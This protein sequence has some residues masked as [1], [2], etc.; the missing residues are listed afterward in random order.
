MSVLKKIRRLQ[1]HIPEAL[2]KDQQIITKQLSSII[3]QS[4]TQDLKTNLTRKLQ[5]LEH[6]LETSIKQR[7]LRLTSKPD[8]TFPENLP[9]TAKKD[10]IIQAIIENQVIIIAGETGSGKST[11]IP[12]MCLE[13]GQGIAGKIGCTQP[14]RIAA[15]SIGERIAMEL[16]VELGQ[17]VGY[18][19][20]FTDKSNPAT[21]IKIMTD[22][23]LLAETQYDRF[24]NEYD[25][26]IIDEAHERNLNIDFLLGILKTLLPKRRELKLIITSATI[27]TDKFSR[28]FDDAPV[29]EV[30]GRTYP[31]IIEYQ[32]LNEGPEDTDDITHVDMAVWSVEGL[33]RKRRKGDILIF[34]PTEQ[35]IL[36]TCERLDARQFGNI[37]I[38]PL[39]AR[40]RG[41]Q[42]RQ[43]F[44]S[45][46]GQ[47][48]VVATNIAETSLTIPGIKYVIDTG[49]ARISQ[50]QPR[51]RTT[52]LPVSLISKS[53]ADQRK[54]RCGRTSGGICIRLYSEEDYLQRQEFTPPE[55]LRANLSEVIL[56]MIFLKL[57]H[58]SDFPF[59]DKP[60]Q[61]SINDSFAILEELGAIVKNGQHYQLTQKGSLM[62]RMPL[63]P[64][65]SRM[66]LEA[67]KEGCIEEV[68]VIAAALCIRDPRERPMNKA[69]QADQ[70]HA[71]FQDTASDFITLLNIWNRYNQIKKELKTQN[72]IRKFSK[73][74][75]LSFV[76]M[77][78][79]YD[80]HQQIQQVL[81]EQA[82]KEIKQDT[83]PEDRYIAIHRAILTG[84][85]SNIALQK[86]KNIYQA[87][88]GREIMLFPGSTIFNK[89]SS[90]IVAAEMVKTSRLFARTVAQIDCQWLEPLGGDLCRSS[91]SEPHW[92]R[93]RGEVRAYEQ[94]TLFGLV[95]V[96][97]RLVSYGRLDP[98]EAHRVFV[99]AGLVETRIRE[100]FSF[101]KHNKE[102]I[103]KVSSLEDKIRRRN[104]LVNEEVIYDFY[105]ER[106]KKVYDIRTLKKMIKEKGGDNFLKLSKETL[107]LNS[108]DQKLVD[109]F[110]DYLT[111]QNQT[112]KLLYKFAPGTAEDGLTI[113]IPASQT[114]VFPFEQLE[115]MVPGLLEDKITSLIKA[116]PKHYRKQL[117]PVSRTVNIIINEI[118]TTEDS[119]LFTLARFIHHRFGVDIPASTWQKAE[120][121][122][123]LKMRVMI[124]DKK[125]Q[126]I[127]S[128]RDYSHLKQVISPQL[129][130]DQKQS[131]AWKEAMKKWE[132]ED[133]KAWPFG[134][135][136]ENLQLTPEIIAYPGLHVKDG[137]INLRL[138][139]NK[140]KA[141]QYHKEGVKA[142]LKLCLKKDLKLLIKTLKL[143][144]EIKE[145]ARYFQRSKIV[146]TAMYNSL[147]DRLFM[148]EIR[149]LK[150]FESYA[151]EMRSNLFNKGK[152]L[153]R[154][155]SEALLGYAQIRFVLQGI[156]T[157][158]NNNHLVWA[159]CAQIRENLDQVV[160]Q[161]FII[162]F[163][164]KR[165]KHLS[166]YLK[167]MEI[168]G[169]RGSFDVTKDQKKAALIEPFEEILQKM[170]AQL[171]PCSSNEKIACVDE[172][173][174]M[175][176]EYKVSIF[177]PELKTAIPVSP[178]RLNKMVA[179][180][181]RIF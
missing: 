78:E 64:K 43:V 66:I 164:L 57:G 41:R 37:T 134:T 38:L 178:K 3:R 28:A 72:K 95:I 74:H 109:K 168:R 67:V 140:E 177:A 97:R 94:V 51:T 11:Q 18:K 77:Q 115:W 46:P 144:G 165:F 4:K 73:E 130:D 127:Q 58:V 54:G 34:M 63:D 35:D 52:S 19:I 151:K 133:L 141:L 129:E 36:E 29:I 48:I 13:A 65:L 157:A 31:V 117:L 25:A 106:L 131:S 119:L 84:H 105:S 90:W 93:S 102:L 32:P 21:Y 173:R 42:Q 146:E 6:R 49:L 60:S 40:L 139:K 135:L 124:T 128:S 8:L 122:K 112:F 107:L 108:P 70:K 142:L 120:V 169:Q 118:K 137:V 62:A 9:I 82:F 181:N 126:E 159:M 174:W 110:P 171:T 7:K 161:N 148:V 50:Y 123:H 15:I 152:E 26:L 2:L 85:L 75:F 138:F 156:E 175:I 91:Y 170:N 22:G 30:Q 87:S 113:K 55:I 44:A 68:T 103:R 53:S 101:L 149:L 147:V 10:E 172:Y 56:R 150:D 162:S 16:G 76:R 180:I 145:A 61:K 47:K 33:L 176:E 136:P 83:R 27:D 14:R 45:L 92:S 154:L 69:Y 88:R 12:K 1:S 20:R 163:P 39:F 23:I 17:A 99:Q 5:S 121:Y 125:G 158:N 79:W 104:V 86:E 100:N 132:K 166:R 96:S 114:H 167:A 155:A 160:P 153:M 24:L 179:E 80:L 98:D 71:A 59:V 111:S 143:H 89:G 116:L 81:Q